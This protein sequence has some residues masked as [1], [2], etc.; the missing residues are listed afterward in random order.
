MKYARGRKKFLLCRRMLASV[1]RDILRA[2]RADPVTIL[3][4]YGAGSPDVSETEWARSWLEDP[5]MRG[6]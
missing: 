5:R 3:F 6:A 1:A 2:P 4:E